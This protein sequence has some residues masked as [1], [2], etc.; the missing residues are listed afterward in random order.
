MKWL[1][2]PLIKL[3]IPFWIGLF[4]AIALPTPLQAFHIGSGI[5]LILLLILVILVLNLYVYSYRWLPGMIFCVF[6]LF[7]GYQLTVYTT[8]KYFPSHLIFTNETVSLFIARVEEPL[9]EK[10]NSYKTIVNV[11]SI[12]ENGIWKDKSGR[13]LTYFGKEGSSALAQY[14]DIIIIQSKIGDVSSPANPGQFNYKLYLSNQNVYNQVYVPPGKWN[15]IDHQSNGLRAFTIRLREKTIK[16]LKRC[17]TSESEFAV[18]SAILVGNKDW[19]D[20][21]TR[22]GFSDAG[23]MHILCVSGMHVGILFIIV[24]AMLSFLN[25]NQLLRL[26][27]TATILVIIWFYAMITGLSSPVL[28]ASVMF[29]FLLIGKS[30]NRYTSIYNTLAASIILLL[31]T[32][33]YLLVNTGFQLSYIAVTGIVILQPIIERRWSPKFW[34]AKKIWALISVSLAA[35][36]SILPLS[37]LYFHKFPV[38]FLITNIIVIPLVSLILYCGILFFVFSFLQT[39]LDV[40]GNFLIFLIRLL[41]GSIHIIEELPFAV[42]DDVNINLVEALVIYGLIMGFLAFIIRKKKY[43]FYVFTVCAIVLSVMVWVKRFNQ[44]TRKEIIVYQINK[45]S[46]YDLIYGKAHIL[47]TDSLLLRDKDKVGFFVKGSWIKKG[48]EDQ[49]VINL[50]D[51]KNSDRSLYKVAIQKSNF[52]LFM[53]KR[54]VVID[55]HFPEISNEITELKINLIILRNN[56]NIGLEAVMDKLKPEMVV[57]DSSNSWRRVN[58]WIKELETAGIPYHSVTTSGAF[59]WEL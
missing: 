50:D 54:I 29:S 52:I 14:G 49:Q 32:D 57:F 41:N 1:K 40:L 38:Y 19:L 56:P 22:K 42:I 34:L 39:I 8:D 11:V 45:H 58:K 59:I 30:F 36:I 33:P 9:I 2:F 23:A 46:A 51:I 13:V 12:K 10:K 20:N 24:N 47:Y 18:A 44:S 5:I 27:K 4:V 35:Q 28:R 21:E 55:E 7:I 3:L 43:Q 53:G 31:V 48:L 26:F 6:M 37:L 25:R 16:L 15:K 17:S